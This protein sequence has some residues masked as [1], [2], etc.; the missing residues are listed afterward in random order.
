MLMALKSSL[1]VIFIGTLTLLGKL[2]TI[3]TSAS[4]TITFTVFSEMTGASLLAAIVR[5]SR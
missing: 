1:T 4:V 5:L 3:F 2:L